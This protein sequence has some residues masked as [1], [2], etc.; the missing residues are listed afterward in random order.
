MVKAKRGIY[1]PP[2]KGMQLDG[3]NQGQ[4]GRERYDAYLERAL[5]PEVFPDTINTLVGIMNRKPATFELPT[6]LEP[7]LERATILGESLNDVLRKIHEQQL[8]TARVGLNL[9]VPEAEVRA[10][11][12]LPLLSIYEAEA[13]RNWDD[14]EV[15]DPTRQTL[16]LVVLDASEYKRDGFTWDL[17]K[18]YRVLT[19]GDFEENESEGTYFNGIFEEEVG[20]NQSA[21]Q[22]PTLR[23]RTL[24]EIPFV[25]IGPKD[26]NINPDLPPLLGL[27]NR[28]FAIYKG[29]ADLRQALHITSEETLVTIGQPLS[30]GDKIRVGTGARIAMAEGGDVK[31][32]GPESRALQFQ[33]NNLQRDY[34]EAKAL[35]ARLSQSGSQVE[36]GEALRI[37]VAA[38]TANLA[39][40]ARAAAGGL[41][42][43]LR[44]AARWLEIDPYEV[45]ITPNLDFADD[46][47]PFSELNEMLTFKQ[48][49]GVISHRTMNEVMVKRDLTER[50]LE[51]ELAQ[52]EEE[53]G[54][55]P[56]SIVDRAAMASMQQG[57]GPFEDDDE[58]NDPNDDQDEPDDADE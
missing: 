10:P 29:E 57:G 32:I 55:I 50:S 31:Y 42:E 3:L 27:A 4:Q 48:R 43:I 34:D 22:A 45:V 54:I 19:L 8:I 37:R 18:K 39:S 14:G 58:P 26:I 33:S 41:Q 44:M 20:F 2:T 9:D 56:Q 53:E 28:S 6:A 46:P 12:M 52:I 30:D 16:N 38:Q 23:G 35:S 7:M 40:I 17:V 1:L 36:S 15:L 25:F 21:M 5:F 13:I 11:D 24:G 49:G 51:E 47:T